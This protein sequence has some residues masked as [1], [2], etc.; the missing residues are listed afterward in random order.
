MGVQAEGALPA[1][2][3]T[4][5]ETRGIPSSSI[6]ALLHACYYLLQKKKRRRGMDMPC[7]WTAQAFGLVLRGLC[8]PPPPGKRHAWQQ[9]VSFL[10]AI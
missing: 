4:C 9:P 5:L 2:K 1:T 6:P 7:V 3:H 10:P 8:M